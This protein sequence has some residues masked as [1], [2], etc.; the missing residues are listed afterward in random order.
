M[1]SREGINKV[2][3]YLT[4]KH[5]NSI[6][7]LAAF[8]TIRHKLGSIVSI[9]FTIAFCSFS[10]VT[11]DV[12]VRKQSLELLKENID[13]SFLISLKALVSGLWAEKDESIL[14]EKIKLLSK[15]LFMDENEIQQTLSDKGIEE[16]SDIFKRRIQELSDQEK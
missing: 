10:L 14:T 1:E 7:R 11:N 13:N 2:S 12:D 4:E 5:D 8:D 6:A 9:N 16:V 15:W 3:D